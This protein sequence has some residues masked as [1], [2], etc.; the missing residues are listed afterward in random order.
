MTL[1]E[2][3]TIEH[4]AA[5]CMRIA[6]GDASAFDDILSVAAALGW[7]VRAGRSGQGHVLFV[8]G[9]VT[10]ALALGQDPVTNAVCINFLIYGAVW[11]FTETG[12]TLLERV[13]DLW[14]DPGVAAF[15]P[16][17]GGGVDTEGVGNT[18]GA[19][20]VKN[21]ARPVQMRLFD[22]T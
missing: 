3:L 10:S 1:N 4:L 13:D 21:T 15:A 22:Q 12:P 8:E 20:G 2:S 18:G 6:A 7:S 11:P 5:L 19:K 9:A 16:E 17:R 14:H